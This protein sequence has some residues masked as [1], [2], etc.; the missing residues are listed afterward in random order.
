MMKKVAVS[1]V[2]A[3]S[4]SA[5]VPALAQLIP[6][7]PAAPAPSAAS[8]ASVRALLDAMHYRETI[9]ASNKLMSENVL[10]MMRGQGE[11]AIRASTQLDD[12]GRKAALAR[13][14]QRLPKA[15]SAVQK[16]LSDP[17]LVDEL[18]GEAVTLYARYFTP[19]EMD[20]LAAFYR[21]PTGQKTLN[22][23]PQLT[24]EALKM[25]QRLVAPRMQAAMQQANAKD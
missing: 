15:A 1:L 24:A 17:A 13:L 2:A 21:T 4:L 23:M 20:Q 5:G 14:E 7:K 25:G 22:V 11:G 9:V 16:V 3:L 18:Y 6:A 8:Q 12:A 19:Q 10:A